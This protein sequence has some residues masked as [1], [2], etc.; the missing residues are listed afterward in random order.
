MILNKSWLS[1]LANPKSIIFH[2][3]AGTHNVNSIDKRH[4]HFII[5]GTGQVEK[6]D[7]RIEDNNS[8]SD[9]RYAA[10][11]RGYNTKSIGVS[12]AAMAGAREFPWSLGQ[13][14]LTLNQ[15]KTAAQIGAEL[16][17]KYKIPVTPKTTLWHSEVQKNLGV[18]QNGKWDS[19]YIP[20]EGK[21]SNTRAGNFLRELIKSYMKEPLTSIVE[22]VR[23]VVESPA[24]VLIDLGAKKVMGVLENGASWVKVNDVVNVF[25]FKKLSTLNR[26]IIVWTPSGPRSAS[27]ELFGG[28]GYVK[29]NDVAKWI[30]GV[31]VWDASTQTVKISI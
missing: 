20:G 8:T 27:M 28:S 29:S 14:G 9:G 1:S 2:W 11:T 31:A 30:N 23:P 17:E 3:T 25:G 12:C 4:Y 16:C 26:T 10:H 5:D 19:I 18:K 7:Y 22:N 6:G 24:K 15:V 21:V 13:W